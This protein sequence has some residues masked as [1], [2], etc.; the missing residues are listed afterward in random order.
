MYRTGTR[1]RSRGG[2]DLN[3]GGHCY[4]RRGWGD[5]VDLARGRRDDTPRAGLG[6]AVGTF[7]RGGPS[8]ERKGSRNLCSWDEKPVVTCLNA[9][10][11][12]SFISK[13]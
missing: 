4:R 11:A 5:N 1:Q 8:E 2:E 3:Q 7:R 13:E 10:E 12:A 6:K 9:R